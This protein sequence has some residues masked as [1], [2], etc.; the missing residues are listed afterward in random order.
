MNSQKFIPIKKKNKERKSTDIVNID[1]KP[2][3]WGDFK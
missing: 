3:K 2:M 1:G